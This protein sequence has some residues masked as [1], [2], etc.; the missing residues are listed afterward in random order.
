MGEDKVRFS[1]PTPCGGS[2]DTVA[3]ADTDHE[4]RYAELF[5]QLDLNKDGKVDISELRTAL[6][7]R[8]LHQGGAEEIVLESDINQDGLLDFQEFSQYLQAHEKRLWFMFHSVDRNKDGRIDVG[9][10]QHLFHK[11]GVAVTLEQA[12]RI[13]K[14]M[15]RDGTMTIS[16]TEWRDHFLLN[17]FRN[18]EEIVLYWKHSHMFD[19]GEHLT[20]PDEFSEQERRSGLVWR[21]LV[22]GAMAGAVSRTGTAPLDRLKVF[23]QVHGST[24]RGINLWSGLRGMV[25]E[26]GLTSLWRGNGINVL[27]IAPESAIKFMAYE[28]IKWLIRGSR[29]GGSLR[30][31]E[32]F[33]AGSLAGATAQTIIYPME[34]LKTRLTLRKTGQYS[35][36]ADCAKQILKTEGVRAF[37]R[38]YLPNT[39]GIIPYAGIDLAVY[40]TLKNAW[41]QTYCVDS[42]D[43]GVLV[44]LGCGTVSSTCG[45]L[46]SYPL[47]LIRTRMQAQATTEGKP[48]LSMMGQFKYII[49][50]E[51]LPGLYRGITPNFLKVIPAVS[52]SYVVYEHMKKILGVGY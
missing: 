30:V 28:Q 45:Q 35:G 22:A 7:A 49:S 27:K 16:W 37:Y 39:L 3:I 12:S 5:R 21:Q 8:G 51:G 50:Q 1:A 18:M 41:L 15:D 31:Q 44:L 36:M 42:A 34:V 48:K 26:G 24:A 52:I 40:E 46:A 32:R 23:L 11:L 10:I 4:K 33:I 19:I 9:E 38:G 6:A 20:V 25:R 14:S 29:E 47:A 2:D 43:P 17:T 13:L